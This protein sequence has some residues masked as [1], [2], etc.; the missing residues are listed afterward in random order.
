MAG[1]R[2]KKFRDW[3]DLANQYGL[4]VL[5][6]PGGPGLDYECICGLHANLDREQTRNALNVLRGIRDALGRKAVPEEYFV[7]ACEDEEEARAMHAQHEWLVKT[8]SE[9]AS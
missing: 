4:A 5:T 6:A 8:Q 3:A 1:R 7:A 2:K 9:A